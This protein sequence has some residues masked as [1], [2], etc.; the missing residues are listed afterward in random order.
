MKPTSP[1]IHPKFKLNGLP[2]SNAEELLN[3]VD[4]LKQQGAPYEVSMASFLEDWLNFEDRVTVRTSGS[5]GD[6]K[7]IT[8]LKQHM[9]H[10]ALATGAYFKVGEGTR[11]LLCLSSDYI[12]GKM[13]LVR[14][15]VLG[16]DLHVVAPEKDALVE[17]DNAY[18]FVA[19]VPYQVHHSLNALDKVKKLIVGGGA[20]SKE[21]EDRLQDKKTEVFATYGMTETITHVAVRRINGFAR[22]DTFTALSDVKFSKDD[23]GCLVI[24]AP[25]VS[26]QEVVTNDLVE[27][28]S[29][30]SFT[31]LGR[32]DN[33]INSAGVKMIPEEI[34]AKLSSY[35]EIP[36]MIGAEDDPQLGQRVILVLEY[37]SKK[38]QPDYTQVLS[39]LSAYERPKKIYTLSQFP[40]TETGKIK[41]ADVLQLLRKYRK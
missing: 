3:F 31:W 5:T 16:W 41:R 37:P 4:E 40:Y 26:H 35:I 11:A 25:K 14:A 20:I 7:K 18:D 19:M 12:A 39:A 33:V 1:T 29:S 22:S 24:H 38:P 28:H 17:Y 32:F 2:Y 10:S 9:I 30:L 36:F 13:M 27:L 34:E 6:P 23:R 21:L 15:M 8:L